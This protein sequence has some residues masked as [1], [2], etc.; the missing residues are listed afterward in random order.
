MCDHQ[1]SMTTGMGHLANTVQ[2]YHKVELF[3]YL[4]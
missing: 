3:I 2:V 1:T 4:L